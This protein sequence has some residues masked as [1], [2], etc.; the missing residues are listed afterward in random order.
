MQ[1]CLQMLIKNSNHNT[2][3]LWNDMTMEEAHKKNA[4]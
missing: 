2:S 1:K 3:C 4:E